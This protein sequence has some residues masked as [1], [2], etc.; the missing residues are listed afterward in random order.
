MKKII[1]TEKA[2]E[3][4]GSYSQAVRYGQMLYT[5]GQISI[6]PETGTL[7]KGSIEKETHQVMKNLEAVLH[8][9][10]LTF[11]QV[12]KTTIFITNMDDFRSI[13]NVYGSYFNPETAPARETV[14]VV[15][16]PK[17]VRVEIS[18]IAAY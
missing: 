12:V 8:E 14:Q 10:G 9:A 1:Y 15:G 13:N 5:S 18:L 3:P 7:I 4:I 17:N 2:P 16:L 6:S 11:E